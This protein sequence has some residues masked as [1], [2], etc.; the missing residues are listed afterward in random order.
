MMT[1][2]MLSDL[3]LTSLISYIRHFLVRKEDYICCV[4]EYKYEI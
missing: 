2:I 4:N 1:P 3:D